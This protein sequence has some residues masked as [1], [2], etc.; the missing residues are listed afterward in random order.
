MSTRT[1]ETAVSNPRLEFKESF[2]QDVFTIIEELTG[3]CPGVG[4]PEGFSMDK[5]TYDL[6]HE[7]QK[8]HSL[9]KLFISNLKEVK[10]LKEWDKIEKV[11]NAYKRYWET[12]RKN[13]LESLNYLKDNVDFLWFIKKLEDLTNAKWSTET[14]EVFL[15]IGYKNSGTYDREINV[16]RLGTHESNKKYLVYTLYHELV[17]YHIVKHMKINIKDEEEEILCRA[18]FSIVFKEDLIAQKHWKEH[19]TQE[20]IETIEK[21][22]MEII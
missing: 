7:L 3:D 4:L 20:D 21:K 14:L 12:H 1:R 16:I 13:L 6:F 9:T 17:H 5:K 19:L 11:I 2:F 18:I 8:E 22:V 10:K 15:T